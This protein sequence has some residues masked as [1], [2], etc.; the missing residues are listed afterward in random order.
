MGYYGEKQSGELNGFD[1]VRPERSSWDQQEKPVSEKKVVE[2]TRL[3]ENII[4]ELRE[5]FEYFKN[6]YDG[7]SEL[8]RFMLLAYAMMGGNWDS[9]SACYCPNL[10]D[11]EV[12]NFPFES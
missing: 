11:G 9:I 12:A 5:A 1:S 10:M 3:N 7:N 8:A 4:K 6:L 2:G